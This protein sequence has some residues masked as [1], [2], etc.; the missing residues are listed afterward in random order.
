MTDLQAALDKIPFMSTSQCDAPAPHTSTLLSP[1]PTTPY[2]QNHMPLF[3]HPPTID[4]DQFNEF[5]VTYNAWHEHVQRISLK[6]AGL[7]PQL[8]Y[9]DLQSSRM[10]LPTSAIPAPISI[11]SPP[12]P[13]FQFSIQN[14]DSFSL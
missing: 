1:N 11:H 13:S 8:Q 10:E 14:R 4:T 2:P 7:P 12:C 5:T 6:H 3:N 9:I